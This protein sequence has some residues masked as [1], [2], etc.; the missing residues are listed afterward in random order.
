MCKLMP[1]KWFLY[2][3]IFIFIFNLFFSL[4]LGIMAIRY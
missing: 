2:F 4:A 3:F 1:Y